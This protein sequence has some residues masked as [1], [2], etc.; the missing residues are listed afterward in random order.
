MSILISPSW[1]DIQYVWVVLVTVLGRY[2]AV[3]IHEEQGPPPRASPT[4]PGMRPAGVNSPVDT[5]RQSHRPPPPLL[6]DSDPSKTPPPPS[7][8][9]SSSSSATKRPHRL[10]PPL[11]QD[12]L[13]PTTSLDANKKPPPPLSRV[14]TTLSQTLSSYTSSH[15]HLLPRSLR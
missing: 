10:P 14:P 6:Q 1:E 5:V 13:T 15:L 3:F 11:P 2:S 7:S 8:P 12:S 9:S 4:R